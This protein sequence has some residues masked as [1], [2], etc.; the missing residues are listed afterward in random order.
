MTGM[1][2]SRFYL[3]TVVRL[4]GLVFLN[5]HKRYRFQF[6]ICGK[7]LSADDALTPAPDGAVVL[8]RSGINDFGICSVAKWTLQVFL[9]PVYHTEF[10][11]QK[12]PIRVR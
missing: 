6:L 1:N 12:T 3:G 8:R 4:S 7:T 5:D 2:D 11:V 10:S 9:P